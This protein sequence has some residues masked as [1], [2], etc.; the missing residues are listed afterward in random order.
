MRVPAFSALLTDAGREVLAEVDPVAAAKDPLAAASQLRENPKV[1]ALGPDLPVSELVNAVMTQVSLRERGRAKFGENAE[2]MFF[3]PNGLEQST[4]R[5]VAEYRAERTA[6]HLPDSVAVSGGGGVRAGDLCCGIGADL[7]ALAGR[8]V[9]VEGVDADP[10]TVAVARANIE[11][12]GMSGHARVR[13]GDVNEVAAGDYP[14]LFCDPARRGGRGR[15]FDPAA[16][17]PPWDVAT[18]LA[19]RAEAACLKAAPGIPHEVLSPAASAEWISVDGELKETALWFGTLGFGAEGPGGEGSGTAG[20][21]VARR[22]ATVLHERT[23]LLASEGSVA[24]LD[25]VPDL[26]P[27]PVAAARRYLYDPDPAVVRSHL[28][29]EAAARV[30]G[31]LLDERIAYFTSDRAE[32]SPLWR[33]LEVLE[34][35]PFSLKRL[36]AAVRAHKAGTVTIKKRGS[37]VDTEKLRRDLRASGPESVT[38]V[39]TRIGEKPFSLLCREVEAPRTA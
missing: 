15:V 1:A 7:L 10:L 4:R 25:E 11:A 28:V 22:R 23:G 16:Y 27:A 18:R 39:L 37:A 33:V 12:L 38:V 31:A 34:F 30:D 8:G 26:G 29:A 19:E 35:A 24:H 14:L 5:T 17:S 13:E 2:R 32:R 9:S 21:A 3:T 6:R 20:G 36:R